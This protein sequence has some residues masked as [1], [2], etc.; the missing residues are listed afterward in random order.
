MHSA[1]HNLLAIAAQ[2]GDTS[3][4]RALCEYSHPQALPLALTI[5][6]DPQLAGDAV[7]DIWGKNGPG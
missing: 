5:C 7:Q 1:A 3:A 4:Y 2:D 6:N